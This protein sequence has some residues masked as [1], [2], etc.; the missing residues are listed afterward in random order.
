MAREG[1][2]NLSAIREF[3][4]CNQTYALNLSHE[5]YH[6]SNKHPNTCNVIINDF[7]A[8]KKAS[9]IM[10][11]HYFKSLFKSQNCESFYHE[12]TVKA[13]KHWKLSK[14]SLRKNHLPLKHCIHFLLSSL[15][16][17]T[18]NILK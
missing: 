5:L 11:K 16:P 15:W 14:Y 4:S 18:S 17:P 12:R 13:L 3:A 7:T 9:S 6:I 2:A 8:Q 10:K 1:T